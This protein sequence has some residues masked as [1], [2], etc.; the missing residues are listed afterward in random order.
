MCY[1][2]V[3]EAVICFLLSQC[4]GNIPHAETKIYEQFVIATLLRHKT[5]HQE[6]Q[7][8]TFLNNLC[9]ED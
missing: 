1:L 4:E 3:H 7:T 6:E 9:R 5:S 8:L 2:P